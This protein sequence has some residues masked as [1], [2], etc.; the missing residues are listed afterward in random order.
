MQPYKLQSSY[1]KSLNETD[2][3]RFSLF[4]FWV[5][6]FFFFFRGGGFCFEEPTVYILFQSLQLVLS[7]VWR[8][9]KVIIVSCFFFVFFFFIFIFL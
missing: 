4:V 2:I 8:P 5:F 7:A 9:E 6:F 3:L 1:M